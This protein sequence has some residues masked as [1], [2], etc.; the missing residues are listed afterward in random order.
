MGRDGNQATYHFLIISGST[1]AVPVPTQLPHLGT[2]L[3][4]VNCYLIRL[5]KKHR[6]CQSGPVHLPPLE[7]TE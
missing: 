2:G 5:G 6:A 3:Q 7:F 4:K 1:E